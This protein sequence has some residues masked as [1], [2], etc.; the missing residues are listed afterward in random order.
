[1]LFGGDIL[2]RAGKVIR[3]SEYLSTRYHVVVANPP[4]MGSGNM[5][6]KLS[7]FIGKF[8]EDFK[9]DLFSAF[10][11]RIAEL[12]KASGYMGLMSPFVWMFL[13][14]YEKLRKQINARHPLTSLIQLEY[15]GF[16][17][18]TVPICAFTMRNSETNGL[19]AS[20]IRLANFRGAGNQS[21]RA[22]EAIR[23][24]D[25]GWMH[26]ASSADFQN[27]P[28]QTIAYWIS[29]EM[30]DAFSY[31]RPLGTVAQPRV[32]LQ[33][34]D[35]SRFLRLWHE[36]SLKKAALD[37]ASD[38]EAAES[39]TKWFPY[40]KGGSFRRWYGNQDFIINWENDGAELKSMRPKS[41]IRS[42]HYYFNPSISWSK[43]SSGI[44]A[45]RFFPSGFIFDV[46]GTSIFAESHESR[47]TLLGL[48]NSSV[49]LEMLAAIAP[50]LNFEV[51]AI[52]ALPVIDLADPVVVDIVEELVWLSKS[53]WDDSETS[54][55]FRGLA[56]LG[57]GHREGSIH[58]CVSKVRDKGRATVKRMQY[59][60]ETSNKRIIERFGL[61]G[62]VDVAVPIGRI[63]LAANPIYRY[64]GDRAES[65]LTAL[66]NSDAVR[67]LVS[68][69][70]GC[71]FGR[72]SLDT[73]GLVLA[74]QGET[75]AE[76]LAK[77]PSPSF[78]PDKDNVLP[79]LSD[80]WFEDDIVERLR[81]F[82]K[83]SFGEEHFEENL[84]FVEESLGK[85]IRKYFVQDF[86]K[87]HV[88][89]YKKRPIYWMFS[90]PKGSFSAL[91]YMHRYRPDT[92][93]V[94]LNDYLHEFQ[95]KLR[96]RR[97][98]LDQ[99][100]VSTVSTAKEQT[101][102]RKESEQIGKMLL[103]LEEWEQSVLYP[104]AT[105]RIDIDLD[106]GVKTNYPKFGT[107]LRKI[108]GL[109]ANE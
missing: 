74:D 68:Y 64:G 79:V 9:A 102:A 109:E 61:S 90:S 91:I 16:Q 96:A 6:P 69:A 108:V 76:Y 103:E 31:G 21:P 42:P 67:D 81:G 105:E 49:I 20:F 106:D 50:T 94:V 14:S 37:V 65:T 88:Q 10:I 57:E 89:R 23:N 7:S 107:A 66:Q 34:G 55:N 60:E 59:L 54:W 41:V 92:V 104:L 70:V 39:G 45:F 46:A 44:P 40:N 48:M 87:D 1:T 27:I 100:A 93:S 71:M 4:Y 35:N 30:A 63:S 13:G 77:V 56:L 73:P 86:Y 84:R 26:Y 85:D 83:A 47:M 12:S 97:A 19:K 17:G 95:A 72:Y 51:G 32:G 5:G 62:E 2:E 24:P 99:V 82:L 8:Y 18:A 22:L 43:I 52:A 3:Q 15:S 38:E 33:T 78:M 98:N 11:A 28:G 29:P 101:A 36:V 75:L 58:S 25:C 53:D 80:A